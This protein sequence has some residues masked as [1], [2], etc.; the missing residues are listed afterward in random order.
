M[1]ANTRSNAPSIERPRC[2]PGC[3]P[4]ETHLRVPKAIPPAEEG[5]APE[6][7]LSGHSEM[8]NGRNPG[9]DERLMNDVTRGSGAEGAIPARANVPASPVTMG[10]PRGSGAASRAAAAS[11]R[12]ATRVTSRSRT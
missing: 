5:S 2:T 11:K 10:S 6:A 3:V 7:P 4:E 8:L 1:K 12:R 9:A